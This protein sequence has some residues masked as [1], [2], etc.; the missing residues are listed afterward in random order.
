VD[1]EIEIEHEPLSFPVASLSWVDHRRGDRI[2]WKMRSMMLGLLTPSRNS[3]Q[4]S[5]NGEL[6]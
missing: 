1:D 5:L 4:T 2:V 6:S 3:R